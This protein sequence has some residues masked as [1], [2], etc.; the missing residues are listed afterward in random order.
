MKNIEKKYFKNKNNVIIASFNMQNKGCGK[1]IGSP[2]N[3]KLQKK[4]KTYE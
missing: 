4:E 1:K 3:I 2:V